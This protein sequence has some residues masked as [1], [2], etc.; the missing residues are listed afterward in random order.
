MAIFATGLTKFGAI[1]GDRTEIGCNAVINPGSVLGR[2]CIIYPG[3]NFRGVLP[4]SSVV[5]MRQDIQILP[6]HDVA[7]F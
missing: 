2:D 7:K 5:K 3:V 1:V 6:R 4:E